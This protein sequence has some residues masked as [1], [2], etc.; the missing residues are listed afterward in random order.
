M[1]RAVKWRAANWM[2]GVRFLTGSDYF[3]LPTCQDSMQRISW[4]K[5]SDRE[6]PNLYIV[7]RLKIYW[8]LPSHHHDMILRHKTGIDKKKLMSYVGEI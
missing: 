2:T 6:A 7:K 4:I 1:D 8:A 3:S 5:R